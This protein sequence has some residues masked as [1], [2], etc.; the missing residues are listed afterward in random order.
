MLIDGKATGGGL[1]AAESYFGRNYNS[2]FRSNPGFIIGAKLKEPTNRNN[3]KYIYIYVMCLCRS[4]S[5]TLY[6]VF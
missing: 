2:K 1:Y 6:A 5:W 4:W 3:C